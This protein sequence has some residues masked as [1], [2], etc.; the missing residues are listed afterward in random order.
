MYLDPLVHG[1]YP[2]D[3]LARL[4]GL[5]APV[6]VRDG[7]LA[8]ISTPIDVLG[9]NYYFDTLLGPAGEI[10]GGPLTGLGWPITPAGM[11]ELLL[12]LH[13][14][15]P[16]L[17]VV[18]TEN[19]AAFDDAPDPDGAVHDSG[20]TRFLAA[21]VDAVDQARRAG[22][23]VRGYFVWTL[24]DNFEWGHGYGPRF[25]LVRVDHDTQRRVLKDSAHWYREHIRTSRRPA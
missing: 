10:R 20:R 24:L 22:A 17:P 5:G 11:T 14:D 13:R 9:V 19:G 4:D 15:Y 3:V 7:D 2:A 16:G 18:I 8:V 1:R 21:H 23:D 6:P 25:G 12:R